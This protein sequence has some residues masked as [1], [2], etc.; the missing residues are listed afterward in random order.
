MVDV[1]VYCFLEVEFVVVFREESWEGTI[2]RK[3]TKAEYTEALQHKDLF[4]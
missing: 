1:G 4:L 2:N 3:P